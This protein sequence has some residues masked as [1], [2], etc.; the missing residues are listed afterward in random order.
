MPDL[1]L[2]FHFRSESEDNGPLGPTSDI[3]IV[4]DYGLQ[5]TKEMCSL[6]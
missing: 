6:N 2:Q 4:L 5:Q 1:S 3:R